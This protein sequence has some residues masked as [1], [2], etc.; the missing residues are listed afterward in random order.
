MGRPVGGRVILGR[1]LERKDGV[2]W[3]GLICLMVGTSFGLLWVR[4]WTFGSYVIL[5]NSWK[6]LS[7]CAAG[8]FRG[9]TRPRVCCA[10]WGPWIVLFLRGYGV[11][12]KLWLG[13]SRSA[14]AVK[15]QVFALHATRS[16]VFFFLV[17]MRSPVEV[18]SGQSRRCVFILEHVWVTVVS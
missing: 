9:R 10:V 8:D 4:R 13:E 14:V 16:C 2:V 7:I 1:I 12:G 6:F 3:I 17:L 18:S 11:V 5:K 15:A